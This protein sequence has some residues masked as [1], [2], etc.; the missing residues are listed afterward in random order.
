MPILSANFLTLAT[1]LAVLN[2]ILTAST[3][4]FAA[5]AIAII[6]S[7]LGN[8]PS[9]SF[10]VSSFITIDADAVAK[11]VKLSLYWLFITTP[12][13]PARS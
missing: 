10:T 6:V 3:L 13:A 4:I 7:A 12:A 11:R 9:S 1:P 8:V 5:A 2:I